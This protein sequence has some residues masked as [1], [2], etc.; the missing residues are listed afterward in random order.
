MRDGKDNEP[1]A[2]A[3]LDT[4]EKVLTSVPCAGRFV[5]PFAALH[6]TMNA[7]ATALIDLVSRIPKS[8]EPASDDPKTR[9]EAIVTAAAW[10]AAGVSGTLALPP[11]PLGWT[12][13]LPD[14][15]AIWRIQQSMVADIA[16]VYGKS[17]VLEKEAMI[18]CLFKHGSA[19][20]IRDLVVRA[21]THF[22]IRRIG[23]RV[24]QEMAQKVGLQIT[25]TVLRRAVSRW[26]PGVGA[27]LAA[28]Y[29][30]YDTKSVGTTAIEFFSSD[31][32]L[33]GGEEK[34]S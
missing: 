4:V 25:R 17:S 20:L 7:I 10:K 8:D 11:G 6:S 14:L 22:L 23:L 32:A 12:T 31:L 3:T 29:A 15:L 2:L 18:Y 27:I 28:T 9:G 33:D 13:V 1:P 5:L 26:L 24:L 21:G 30:R 34:R 16:A 19:Q